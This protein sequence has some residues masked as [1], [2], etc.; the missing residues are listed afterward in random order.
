MLLVQD[1]LDYTWGL[2]LRNS[3]NPLAAEYIEFY[4]N[5]TEA[6]QLVDDIGT[7]GNTLNQGDIPYLRENISNYS[8]KFVRPRG[9]SEGRH[10]L[11][12]DRHWK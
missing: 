4:D 1:F 7:D 10:Y 12:I 5:A 6:L 8:H 11:D 9:K 2:W 3:S